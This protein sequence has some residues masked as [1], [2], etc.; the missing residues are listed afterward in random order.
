MKNHPTEIA[1]QEA[2]NRK[3]LREQDLIIRKS[4][5]ITALQIGQINQ[6]EY[7][8]GI[9]GIL[10]ERVEDTKNTTAK[11]LEID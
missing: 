8:D 9:R 2:N 6:E 10:K 5:L 3:R 7:E 1:L 11:I 4:N